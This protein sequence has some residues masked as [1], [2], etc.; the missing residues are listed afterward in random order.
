MKRVLILLMIIILLNGCTKQVFQQE[1][2]EG[3]NES[4]KEA[5][6][7]ETKSDELI[8][9]KDTSCF[10]QR[11][12]ECKPTKLISKFADGFSFEWQ[13]IG[14]KDVRCEFKYTAKENPNVEFVGKWMQ[15]TVPQ[16]QAF[17][18]AVINP[19]NCY[20]PLKDLQEM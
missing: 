6:V 1:S 13:I 18:F 5:N 15:C 7:L 16:G 2:K 3:T 11:F 20:G 14:L 8:D 9:C 19:D 4:I 17:D 10:E 12:L